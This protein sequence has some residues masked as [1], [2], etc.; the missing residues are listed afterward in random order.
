MA[1]IQLKELKEHLQELLD[2]GFIRPTVL[3]WGVLVLFVQKKDVTIR[4]CIDY[5]QLNKVTIKKKYP[6]PRIDDLLDQL[7]GAREGR[8]ISYALRQLKP[9]E[10][11]YHVHDLELTVIV[12]ALKIWRHYLYGVSCEVFT[13]HRSL[14][15]LFKQK[16]LNLRQRRCL[17]LLKDYDITILYHLGKANIVAD[18][19]IRK[20]ESMGSP[21]YLSVMERPLVLDVQA[22]ANRFVRL[23]ISEPSRVLACVVS[24]SSLFE[25]IKARQYNDPHLLVMKDTVQHGDA[26]EVNIRDDGFIPL[27][28]FAYNNSLQSSI[29]IDPY[30]ALYGRRYRSPVGWFDP[31]GARLLGTDLVCD[32]LE[33]AK[34]IQESFHASQSRKKSYAGRKVRDVAYIVGEK[35]LPRF[36]PMKGVMRFGKKVKL[37]PQYICP[38]EVLERVREVAY[39]LALP[40]SLSGAQLVFYISMLRKCY[41]D[42][43]HVWISARYN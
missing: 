10:K 31:G 39:K 6:L 11:N 13:D 43:S 14:Q 12:H 38:F 24:R 36:P 40:P 28:E 29:Q 3:P 2:K 17:E 22:L 30:E 18:A 27:A 8:V 21:A 23:D 9:H 16:D 41:G 42:P 4:M 15:H 20:V 26:K 25:C 19:L 35:T 7:Q 1:P 34:L 5:M 32:A 33:K 37:I